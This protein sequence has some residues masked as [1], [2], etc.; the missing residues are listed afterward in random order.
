[1]TQAG[2][3]PSISTAIQPQHAHTLTAEQAAKQVGTTVRTIH[4]WLH[5]GKLNGVKPGGDKLGWRIPQ[6]EIDRILGTPT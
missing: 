5:Q 3:T 1:M 4:N 6:A 2:T